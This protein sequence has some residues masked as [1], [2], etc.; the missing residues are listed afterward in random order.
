MIGTHLTTVTSVKERILLASGKTRKSLA[1]EAGDI[2]TNMWNLPPVIRTICFIQFFA[3]LGWFPILFYTTL[4][5]SDLYK[6]S[7]PPS[8]FDGNLEDIDAEGARLGSRAQLFAAFLALFTNALCPLIFDSSS[9]SSPAHAAPPKRW[10]RPKIHLATLWAISHL[11]FASCM[12]G[13][14]FTSSATGATMLITLLG[15]SSAIGQWVPFTLLAEAIH[16]TPDPVP[17]EPDIDDDQSI[18]LADTSTHQPLPQNEELFAV[19]GED[20]DSDGDE[21]DAERHGDRDILM[22]NIN[23]RRSWAD[24]SELGEDQFRNGGATSSRKNLSAK[25]GVILGIQNIFIVVPQFLV[26]GMT[27]LIFAI[28]EPQKSVLHGNHPGK[29]PPSLNTTSTTTTNNGTPVSPRQELGFTGP[30][31]G[32][33]SVAI[34]FRIGGIWAIVAFVMTWRLA[35]ELRRHY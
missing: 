19:E 18:L 28:L 31:S 34:I 8:A 21:N 23:A 10:W 27:S 35:K 1:Q 12:F 16:S 26:T 9:S 5:I 22:G 33:N 13:T 7:L 25:A 6:R 24:V 30:P 3:A 4:Y 20:V 17:G 2:W 29:V 15:F 11:I 14:F 32:P